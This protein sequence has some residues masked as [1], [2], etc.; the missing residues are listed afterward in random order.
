MA[1]YQ[2]EVV[3]TIKVKIE[4]TQDQFN[5]LTKVQL[6]EESEATVK[7]LLPSILTTDP[8]FTID[9]NRGFG[10]QFFSDKQLAS[11]D[12]WASKPEAVLTAS[13]PEP[14]TAPLPK[15]IKEI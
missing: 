2:T 10:Q 1:V 15:Y 8:T 3:I 7:S 14:E 12:S 9:A 5:A 4:G 11:D 13:L 6:A